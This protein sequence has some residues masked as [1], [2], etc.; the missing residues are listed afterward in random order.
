MFYLHIVEFS[1]P[2]N[3]ARLHTKVS[4]LQTTPQAD[5][6][7]I[8]ETALSLLVFVVQSNIMTD[9]YENIVDTKFILL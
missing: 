3:T 6:K 8:K 9:I 7:N 1:L 4:S 5:L 2:N